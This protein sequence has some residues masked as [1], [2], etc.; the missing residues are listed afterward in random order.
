MNQSVI[1]KIS[2]D[3]LLTFKIYLGNFVKVCENIFAGGMKFNL[4]VGISLSA[5]AVT[6]LTVMSGP[7]IG[8]LLVT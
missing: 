4:Q 6:P 1:I 2:P 3:Y 5:G 8:W 7:V